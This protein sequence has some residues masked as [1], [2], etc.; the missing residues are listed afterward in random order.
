MSYEQ[1]L[2]N[3]LIVRFLLQDAS[4][5]DI[6]LLKRRLTEDP[7]FKTHFDQIRDTWNHI[8]LEK[9]L[10]DAKIKRDLEKVLS[11]TSKG[12]DK[13]LT[14]HMAVNSWFFKAAAIFIIGFGISWG[15]FK[16]QYAQS[17]RNVSYNTIEIPKGSNSIVNLPDGS[18][19]TLNAQSKLTY[20]D[21]FTGDTRSVYLEG[22]AFFEVA[23]D[24][25]RLFEVNTPELLV[26]VH[27]TSFNIKSYADESTVET[28]LVEGSISLFKKSPNGDLTGSEIK[29][30]PNQQLV[31]YKGAPS[32]ESEK[33]VVAKQEPMKPMKPKLMLSKRID[34]ERFVSWK[35]GLLKIKSEPLDKLAVTLER[36]YNVTIHFEDS[37]MMQY[38]FSGTIQDETIEQVLAAIKLASSINYEIK[39]RDIFIKSKE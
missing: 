26:K 18:R 34:T 21:H 12:S 29:M 33:K 22:E 5:Q 17:H 4:E 9:D 23:K 7:A 37:E 38:R 14:I 39:E 15:L 3:N 32:P 16:Y 11:K 1:D 28:T 20:P 6:D 2:D 19:I 36:R 31:L 30:E 24:N 35:D 10:D 25:D 13:R 27:G 8:E